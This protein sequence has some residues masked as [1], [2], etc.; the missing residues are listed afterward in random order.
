LESSLLGSFGAAAR[1]LFGGSGRRPAYRPK[2]GENR[3]AGPS[4]V[5][6]ARQIY[7]EQPSNNLQVLIRNRYSWMNQFIGPSDSGVEIGAG[8]GLSRDFIRAG[9]FLL[10]DFADH[11]WLDVKQ[12][13]ALQTPFEDASFDFAI[14]VNMIHHLAH[15]LRFFAE[16]DR[17][18]KA[19]GRLIVQDVH[20]STFLRLALRLQRHEGYDFNVSV[21]DDSAVCT[22]P[23]DLWAGNNAIVDLLL[24]DE[25]RFLRAVPN[26]RLLH[27]EHCEFLTFLNS[28]GVT[29]KTVYLPLPMPLLRLVEAVDQKLSN[30]WPRI[31]ALQVRL[32]LQKSAG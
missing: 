17:I 18:L 14:A 32:V 25:A 7:L 12:V 11:P 29:A 2:A 9:S 24:E 8:A 16:M 27:R 4:D 22:D 23:D 28:G 20:C 31:F 15:P 10:T 19:G 5:Q 26:F 3:M 6:R 1:A 21:F 30:A 13:N